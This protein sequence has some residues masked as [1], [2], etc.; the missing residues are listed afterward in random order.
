MGSMR[1]LI[2]SLFFQLKH[3]I[4]LGCGKL[5]RSWFISKDTLASSRAYLRNHQESLFFVTGSGRSGTQLITEVWQHYRVPGSFMSRVSMRMW[6]ICRLIGSALQRR[7]ISG[8]ILSKDRTMS[9]RSTGFHVGMTGRM[10]RRP[11]FAGYV[12]LR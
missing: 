7:E 6:R 11:P 12:E 8:V 9:P 1:T 3:R 10:I 4:Q 2:V 5:W